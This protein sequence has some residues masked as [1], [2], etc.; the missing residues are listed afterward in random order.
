MFSNRLPPSLVPNRLTEA[1][2][3]VRAAG[4][5]LIDLTVTNPT[6]VGLDYHPA[7]L[8]ALAS[9]SA[10]RYDPQPFGLRQ[11]REAVAP[12]YVRKGIDADPDRIVLTA[13]TS[14]AYSLLFK[15][16]CN[17]AKDAVLVPVPSYPLFEHLTA[18]DGVRAIRYRFEYQGR[19][20]L[21]LTDVDRSWTDSVRALLVVSPNNPTGSLL[22]NEELA[23]LAERCASRKAAL[24]VD[25]VFADY[26]LPPAPPAP[27]PRP[28]ASALRPS[29]SGPR[30]LTFR[31]GGLSKSA[32]LPQVKLGWMAV[33]GPDRLVR[34]ALTRLELIADTY[35]SVATPVQT[36][37]AAL[38]ESGRLIRDKILHRVR[39]NYQALLGAAASCAA[40]DVLHADAGWSAVIRVPSTRSEEDLVVDLVEHDGVLVHPGY[41]FDFPHEAFVVVS[42]LPD[43]G[44]FSAGTR[45]LLDRVGV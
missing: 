1:V 26:P 33:D 37:A 6:A 4:R 32:G 25:E 31:L 20:T 41:F 30:P 44:T 29:A 27:P 35:L 2:R 11:A 40:I 34:E 39:H 12:E 42:L 23:S 7:L 45:R 3:K 19:W 10:L 9:R 5:P 8:Q 14:E 43:P 28:P 13:S 36:A 15:L 21:D 16:L 24:I 22:T 38:I 18:L 17:P